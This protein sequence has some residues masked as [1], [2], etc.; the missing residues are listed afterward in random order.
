MDVDR[1]MNNPA[2]MEHILETLFCEKEERFTLSN[3]LTVL[4]KEEHAH[5]IAS[6]Q[7]WVKTGSIHEGEML[8]AG[9]SHFL[10]HM[11]FKGTDRRSGEEITRSVQ[12]AGAYINAYTTFDR[13]V[14]YIET[15]SEEIALAVDILADA[16]LNSALPGEEVVK[17]RDVILREIDMGQDDPDRQLTRT[18]FSNAFHEH[19]YRYPVI[20]YREIFETVTREDLLSYYQE[21]YVPNNMVLV[22]VGDFC[23]LE[24]KENIKQSFSP[25]SRKRLSLPYVPEEPLQLG[26]REE[27]LGGE[28]NICRGSLAFRIPGLRHK[29]TPG[30]DILA[31]ILGNGYSSILWQRLRDNRKIVHY[32]DASCWSPGNA[33]LFWISYLCDPGKQESA[34]ESILEELAVM[35]KEGVKSEQVEKAVRQVLVSEVSLRKTVSGQASRLGMAEVVVGDL[36]YQRTYLE[37]IQKVKPDTVR[38]LSNNYLN[39]DRLT[40]VSLNTIESKKSVASTQSR[41]SDLAEIQT[42]ILNNGVRIVYQVDQRLPKTHM[43]VVSL[44]GSLYEKNTQRGI[45]GLLS[46]LLTRDT[47]RRNATEVADT[48]EKIGG[49]FSEFCGNNTLGLSMEVMSQDYK[50]ALE[51]LGDALLT[52]VFEENTFT[53]ECTAQVA[54]IKEENDDIVLYGRKKLREI[55]FGDHPFKIE[56]IGSEETLQSLKVGDIKDHYKQLISGKNVVAAIFGDFDPDTVIPEI[57]AVLGNLPDG[58][59]GVKKGSFNGPLKTGSFECQLPRE[60]AVVFQA[61]PDVGIYSNEF[62]ISEII[63]ELFSNMSGRLFERVREEK[64]LAYFVGAQ[65]IAGLENGMFYLYAGT[66]PSTYEEVIEEFNLEVTRVQSGEVSEDELRRCQRRLKAQKRMSL[67]TIGARATQ[68]ALNFTYGKQAD[69]WK[70]YDNHIEAVTGDD[71]KRFTNQYFVKERMVNL[72]VKP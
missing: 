40:A 64:S 11:L 67:Q 29:D 37:G 59:F 54:Q 61:Y 9:L 60:Q 39:S 10:E 53:T 14:Y 30:C 6:V 12:A 44:G 43:K 48:I 22:V 62:Y 42:H 5:K 23:S 41:H 58:V 18:L 8:G 15:P 28:V 45:T 17:E 68:A 19:P 49:D 2:A 25:F 26:L 3:G 38:N 7:V 69:E 35:G 34:Q 71:L 51:L 70:Q 33:G 50:L 13:T 72:V 4:L 27:H 47:E 66:H 1:N 55:F 56:S 32:V 57:N 24:L 52:P 36:D 21:R 16:A 46:T 31:S 65:R 63:D 20:G